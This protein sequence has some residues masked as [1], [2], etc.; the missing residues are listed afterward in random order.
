MAPLYVEFPCTVISSQTQVGSDVGEADEGPCPLLLW[1]HFWTP[2]PSPCSRN[3]W[4]HA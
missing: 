2:S 4:R 1:R 3:E